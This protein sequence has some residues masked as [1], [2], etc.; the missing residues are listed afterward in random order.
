MVCHSTRSCATALTKLSINVLQYSA[1]WLHKLM[2]VA[3]L[4]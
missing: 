1:G 2:V 4:V 3:P